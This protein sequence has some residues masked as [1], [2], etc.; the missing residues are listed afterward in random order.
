MRPGCYPHAVKRVRL[1]ETHIS[2]VLLTGKW[3]YK[4]KKPVD[5]GFV[6]F[7]TLALRRRYCAEELRLNR[8]LAPHIYD[9]V[10]EIR[11]APE[12]PR[13]AGNGPL[14]DYAVR[15]RQFPQQ[16]LGDRML[17]RRAFTPKM[18][19]ALAQCIADFHAGAPIAAARQPVG[20]PS[21]VL[22]AARENFRQVMPGL[23][24]PGQRALLLFL[25]KWTRSEHAAKRRAIASRRRNGF[26]RECHGDLHLGNIAVIEGQPVPFDRIEFNASL[27]WIDVMSEVAFLLMDLADHRR[28]DLAS[29]FL[30]GYL[31]TTGDYEGLAILRYYLVY[32]ALVRAKVNVLRARQPHVA[33]R[34]RTRLNA[35]V[36]DYVALARRYATSRPTALMITHGVS[37]S[38]KTT[39]TQSLIECAGAVRIRSDIERKRLFG[40]APL[41]RSGSGFNGG[42]YTPEATVATY[43]RLALLA[44]RVIEAGW[45][46]VVDAAFLKRA[47]RDA[48]RALA[49]TLGVPFVII[50]CVAPPG[51]LAARAAARAAD[52]RDPSEAD[53]AVI[54][55]QLTSREPLMAGELS[56]TFTIDTSRKLTPQTW[57]PLLVRLRAAPAHSLRRPR[58]LRPR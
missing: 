14:L 37:A 4:I 12:S 20:T 34:E 23:A 31:E 30:N 15:M 24:H 2:W 8:R 48:F 46:V 7:S 25:E 33:P 19:D 58:P 49:A 35:L 43:A 45:P 42:I 54:K 3:A 17:G 50:D 1:I 29:R 41:A 10:V 53:L 21:V 47:E 36:R 55:R 28:N 57:R 11:G 51:L 27:R 22:A 40:L 39:A 32:R 13:I 9:S 52:G 38:G 18:I 16:A 5:F 6:D 26:V 56:A 44:Q